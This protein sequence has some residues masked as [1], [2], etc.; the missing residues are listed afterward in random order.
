M[1]TVLE[2]PP[3]YGSLTLEFP[4]RP[5]SLQGSSQAKQ[6]LMA[7]IRKSIE[8][9]QFFFSGEVKIDVL[10]LLHPKERYQG[11]Q[12]PDIDNILKPLIDGLSGIDGILVNDC[13]VQSVSCSWIDQ[14]TDKHN[15]AIELKYSPDDWIKKNNLTWIEISEKLCM[16]LDTSLPNEVQLVLLE[17]WEQMFSFKSEIVEKTGAWENGQMVMPIQMPFHRARLSE[18]TLSTIEDYRSRI[19]QAE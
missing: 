19:T 1:S 13:Q 3:E 18:F 6:E 2:K 16:P 11:I 17:T 8:N 4:L 7:A 9:Y 15:L 14:L 5:I 10:W 12:S